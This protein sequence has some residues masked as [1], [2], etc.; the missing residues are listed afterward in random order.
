MIFC[1]KCW[2]RGSHASDGGIKSSCEL[3]PTCQAE[4]RKA[5]EKA[6]AK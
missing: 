6:P 1:S 3:C 4:R 5:A 2:H